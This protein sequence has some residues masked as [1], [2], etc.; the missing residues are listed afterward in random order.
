MIAGRLFVGNTDVIR[1]LD[2]LEENWKHSHDLSNIKVYTQKDIVF[3]SKVGSPTLKLNDGTPIFCAPTTSPDIID[4]HAPRKLRLSR[5]SGPLLQSFGKKVVF[6][7][8]YPESPGGE[9]FQVT[10]ALAEGNRCEV[11]G[12]KVTP[13]ARRRR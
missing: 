5:F 10:E 2:A 8:M 7:Y 9:A 6:C 1:R 12:S 4:L 13:G 11:P 3:G